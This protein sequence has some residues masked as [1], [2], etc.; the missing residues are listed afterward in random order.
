[1]FLVILKYWDKT[2]PTLSLFQV[3]KEDYIK[4]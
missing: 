2:T 4:T 3:F 1:M